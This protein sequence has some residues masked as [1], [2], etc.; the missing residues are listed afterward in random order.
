VTILAVVTTVTAMTTLA[1]LATLTTLT[2]FT[3][4]VVVAVWNADV[5]VGHVG[6][7]LVQPSDD[8]SAGPSANER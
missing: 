5:A 7:A 1:T 2:T 8:R 3:F 6:P 4:A